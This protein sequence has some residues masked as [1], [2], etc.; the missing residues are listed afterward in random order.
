MP[1]DPAAEKLLRDIFESPAAR[2][3]RDPQTR[4]DH[5]EFVTGCFRCDLRR[6]EATDADA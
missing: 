4:H 3:R 1:T 5:R 6:E 2:R